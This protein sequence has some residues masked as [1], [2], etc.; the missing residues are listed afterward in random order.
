MAGTSDSFFNQLVVG[1]LEIS[2]NSTMTIDYDGR[3]PVGEKTVFL[4]K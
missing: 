2:G 3:N 4:V 1:E